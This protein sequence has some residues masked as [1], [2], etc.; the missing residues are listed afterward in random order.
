MGRCDEYDGITK[1]EVYSVLVIVLLAKKTI[2][3]DGAFPKDSL[4]DAKPGTGS[5]HPYWIIWTGRK[6][7][8]RYSNLACYP[9]VQKETVEII[10]NEG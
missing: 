1:F 7:N 9:I 6:H 10:D 4:D 5:E 2:S 3:R 8:D